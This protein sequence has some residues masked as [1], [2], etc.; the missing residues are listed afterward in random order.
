VQASS[1][2]TQR[3]TAGSCSEHRRSTGPGAGTCGRGAHREGTGTVEP[4][5][6]RTTGVDDVDVSRRKQLNRDDDIDPTDR[7]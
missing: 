4:S 3:C 2:A 5:P 6:C 1:A 7:S